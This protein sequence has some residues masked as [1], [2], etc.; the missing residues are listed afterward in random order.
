MKSAWIWAGI[1][2]LGLFGCSVPAATT[3]GEEEPAAAL[4]EALVPSLSSEYKLPSA[5]Q[6][7]DLGRALVRL[8]RRAQSPIPRRLAAS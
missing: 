7:R 4:A 8:E 1:P 5:V 6:A 3:T 2:V